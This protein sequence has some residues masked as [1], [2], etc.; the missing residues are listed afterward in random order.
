MGWMTRILIHPFAGVLSAYGIGLAEVRVL[1]EKSVEA[2]LDE[3]LLASLQGDF[4]DLNRL[5]TDELEQQ[6]TTKAI[7]CDQ[8]V[9]LKYQVED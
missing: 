6:V 8:K 3:K 9:H 7:E 2:I 1:K 5:A 4:D